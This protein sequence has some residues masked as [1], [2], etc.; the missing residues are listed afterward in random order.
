MNRYLL[1]LIICL[2][3]YP[4]FSQVNV[5]LHME[6]K[7]GQEPFAYNLATQSEM[8][9]AFTITRM[10]YYISNVRL[11]HDGGQLTSIPDLY[12][13]V[14][15]ALDSEFELGNFGVTDL[16]K[17]EFSV[18]VD[19]DHNHLDPTT[20]PSGHPLA[21]QNP[22]MHWGW[23][24]GYRFIALE[25]FAGVDS[26]S[27]NNNYQIHTVGDVNYYTVSLDIQEELVGNEMSI[28]IEADY[29]QLLKDINASNG[30][31][32]HAS[33]G[34][35][36]KVAGNA[37]DFV[38]SANLE[39]GITS[40]GVEGSINVSP[41][42]TDGVAMVNYDLPGFEKLTL[43]VIDLSGRTVF[44][45]DLDGSQKTFVLNADWQ[46]GLYLVRI[47]NGGQLLALEKLV[48]K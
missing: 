33:T 30:V 14:D 34:L 23:S 2:G 48:I 28:H 26:N 3:S 46:P 31:I 25:G 19:P 1:F 43:S 15:P 18:G 9:Y 42:P 24:S 38:F 21:P 12:L 40:P 39:T 13:L 11:I 7:L 16:E 32:S 6:Q 5:T 44:R 36:K 27:T 37:R 45:N 17:I 10:Q 47:F 4:I 22:S 35:S 29:A 41:N 20:Y 8:G